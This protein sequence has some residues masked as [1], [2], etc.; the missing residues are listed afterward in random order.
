M[1]SRDIEEPVSG[2]KDGRFVLVASIGG[3]GRHGKRE[4]GEAGKQ[5]LEGLVVLGVD[6]AGPPDGT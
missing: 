4:V 1:G 6:F 5:A 2:E 3:I